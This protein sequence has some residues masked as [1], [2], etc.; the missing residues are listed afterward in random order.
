M[1]KVA[2]GWLSPQGQLFECSHRGHSSLAAKIAMDLN[3]EYRLDPERLLEKLGWV[4]LTAETS[5]FQTIANSVV[6][7]ASRMFITKKQADTLVDLG[8]SSNEDFKNLVECS[9]PRW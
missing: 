6:I 5:F 1:T 3:T 9:E 2:Y 8:Y 7:I 4:R